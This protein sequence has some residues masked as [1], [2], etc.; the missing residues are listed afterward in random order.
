MSEYTKE[1]LSEVI[2][3]YIED[4]DSS[5]VSFHNDLVSVL[6]DAIDINETRV[7][8]LRGIREIINGPADEKTD[9]TAELQEAYVQVN[10]PH[11]DGYTKQHYQDII[12]KH[13]KIPSRY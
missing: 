9:A 11:N 5:I 3:E 1:K 7:A 4:D 12:D 2:L 8:K 10:S 13:Q 6:S